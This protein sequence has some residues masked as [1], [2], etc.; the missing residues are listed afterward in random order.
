MFV[1]VFGY[2]LAIVPE[3][4]HPMQG[5]HRELAPRGHPGHTATLGIDMG[6]K[7]ITTA[8]GRGRLAPNKEPYLLA[9][10]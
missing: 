4:F 10:V 9:P 6:S 5:E 7:N 8:A 1:V 3:N 2:P